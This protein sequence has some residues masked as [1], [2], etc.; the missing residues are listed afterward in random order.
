MLVKNI[1]IIDV[2]I[3]PSHCYLISII[4]RKMASGIKR[5]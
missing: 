5:P 3:D 2:L 4:T 1:E